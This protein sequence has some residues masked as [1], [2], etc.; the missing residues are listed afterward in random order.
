M[1]DQIGSERDTEALR[2]ALASQGEA[3][4][5]AAR[6]IGLA[7]KDRALEEASPAQDKLISDF[8]LV[9]SDFQRAQRLCAE[10]E[11]GS[12][13]RRE[14]PGGP[15]AGATVGRAKQTRYLAFNTWLN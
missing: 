6:G 9:L 12:F 3:V 10:R 4:A 5:E 1:V 8:R 2:R 11:A 13:P 15:G 7:L 14:V